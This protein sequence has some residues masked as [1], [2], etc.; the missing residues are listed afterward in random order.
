VRLCTDLAYIFNTSVADK[1][2]VI[3][4]QDSAV[5]GIPGATRQPL[6]GDH[7]SIVK[8]ASKEAP[9][10]VI[11]SKILVSLIKKAKTAA[12]EADK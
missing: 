7:L 10:Y 11:V 5:L 3:V 8:Y 12:R 9:N 2:Q 4:N 6:N 1:E